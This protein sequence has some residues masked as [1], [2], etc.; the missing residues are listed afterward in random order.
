[1][2]SCSS[3]NGPGI[4]TL[5]LH[6]AVQPRKGKWSQAISISYKEFPTSQLSHFFSSFHLLPD[7]IGTCPFFTWLHLHH[8]NHSLKHFHTDEKQTYVDPQIR[9]K[10]EDVIH[11]IYPHHLKAIS[12]N[13]SRDIVWVAVRSY[14]LFHLSKGQEKRINSQQEKWDRE[15]M[16]CIA[17]NQQ[18][19]HWFSFKII[20]FSNYLP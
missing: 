15:K 20:G 13:H 19:V 17:F 2:L 7:S 9:S 6:P 10:R 3:L 5:P 1:M 4:C 16:E 11:F 12:Q 14:F 8:G 18:N